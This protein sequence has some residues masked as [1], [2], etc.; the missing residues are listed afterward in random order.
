MGFWLVLVTSIIVT[1]PIS[2]IGHRFKLESEYVMF[3][4]LQR[5]FSN[6]GVKM[7]VMCPAKS[8]GSFFFLILFSAG[9]YL[10]KVW[11]KGSQ[12]RYIFF[13]FY[14]EVAYI[15]LNIYLFKQPTTSLI[16]YEYLIF[17]YE[18]YWPRLASS[19]KNRK[20]WDMTK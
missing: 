15:C 7:L 19:T 1:W 8:H 14:S 5:N 18:N 3:N 2:F 9:I 17:F 11:L 12:N 13:F 4:I 6:F 10:F 20:A 16:Y